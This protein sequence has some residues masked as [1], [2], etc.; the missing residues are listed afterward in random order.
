MGDIDDQTWGQASGGIGDQFS[1]CVQLRFVTRQEP[2]CDIGVKG[3]GCNV[4]TN[5]LWNA[6]RPGDDQPER[7]VREE[8]WHQRCLC[9]TH[10]TIAR[11]HTSSCTATLSRVTQLI[12]A[13]IRRVTTMYTAKTLFFA[14]AA[15]R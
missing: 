12:P 8:S 3:V 10:G 11:G 5:G 1:E 13:A 14:H 6:N 7:L 2:H 15:A 9:L 4:E